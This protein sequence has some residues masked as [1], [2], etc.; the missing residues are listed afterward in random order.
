LKTESGPPGAGSRS[1]LTGASAENSGFD[2][3]VR[4]VNKEAGQNRPGIIAF[5]LQGLSSKLHHPE[6]AKEKPPNMRGLF[7]ADQ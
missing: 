6:A 2:D 1:A 4:Q 5:N 7:S 3:A